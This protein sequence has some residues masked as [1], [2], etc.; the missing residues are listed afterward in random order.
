MGLTYESRGM[1]IK[2]INEPTTRFATKL[3]SCK[4]LRKWRKEEA[5]TG[6]IAAVVQCAKGSL[7]S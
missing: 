6:V 1:I 4:L 5:P 2:Q 7:L 3:I